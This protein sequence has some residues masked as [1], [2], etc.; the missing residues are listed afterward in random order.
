MKQLMMEKALNTN[1]S[2]ISKA[3]MDKGESD[4]S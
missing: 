1:L 3:K 4:N 2:E